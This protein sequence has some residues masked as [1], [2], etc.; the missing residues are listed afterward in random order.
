MWC[1]FLTKHNL[2]NPDNLP[3]ELNNRDLKKAL[4]VLNIMNFSEEERSAYD[5]H[6]KWMMIEAN[7][8]EKRY[9]DGIEE[10]RVEGKS[11]GEKIGEER[12]LKEGIKSEK[13]EIASRMLKKGL[14]IDDI[15]EITGLTRE[16]I[17][18]IK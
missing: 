18:A 10:G 1:S 14:D 13:I 6:L 3:K 4:N 11:E 2:L 15:I 16:E 9:R 12:G 7:T 17:N 8:L 5:D